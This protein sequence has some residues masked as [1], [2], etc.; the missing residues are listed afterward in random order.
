VDPN[1]GSTTSLPGSA[2][3]NC[4]YRIHSV[5]ALLAM[6]RALRVARTSVVGVL[7]VR[8]M[9]GPLGQSGSELRAAL[10]AYR[11]CQD[12]RARTGGSL[13]PTG[14]S[15]LLASLNSSGRV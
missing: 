6:V 11:T 10:P 4:R 15:G 2:N 7:S 13:T 14:L 5:S 1:H 8:L 3:S 9:S 12:A